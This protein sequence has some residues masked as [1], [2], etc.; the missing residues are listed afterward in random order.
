MFRIRSIYNPNLVINR[1]VIGKV[2]QILREQFEDLPRSAHSRFPC[3]SSRKAD[4]RYDHSAST[5]GIS[6]PGS[7]TK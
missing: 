3:S 5:P 7:G 2:Q 1:A 4:T 6:S